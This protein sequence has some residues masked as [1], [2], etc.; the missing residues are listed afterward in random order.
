MFF[1]Q[2]YFV[3]YFMC[4]K[5]IFLNI[6]IFVLCQKVSRYVSRC[7]QPPNNG[8]PLKQTYII[9]VTFSTSAIT[10]TMIKHSVTIILKSCNEIL[11]YT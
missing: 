4:A 7:Y 10:K 8:Y 5:L 6:H 9:G 1:A 2:T 11:P 3:P